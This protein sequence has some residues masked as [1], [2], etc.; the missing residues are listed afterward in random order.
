M[1]IQLYNT[2]DENVKLDKTLT[3]K[4]E[5]TGVLREPATIIN[6]VVNIQAA[7]LPTSNYAY[8]PDFG[9]YYFINNITALR[10]NLFQLDMSVD[11]LMSYKDKIKE[12]LVTVS[13]QENVYDD[14]LVDNMLP[15]ANYEQVETVILTTDNPFQNN[16]KYVLTIAGGK[17]GDTTPYL[18]KVSISRQFNKIA[19]TCF[20][21]FTN[22][23][24]INYQLKD[25]ANNT[26][27][28]NNSFTIKD[29]DTSSYISRVLFDIDISTLSGSY[30]LQLVANT[31]SGLGETTIAE[32]NIIYVTI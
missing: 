4:I 30:Q 20:G 16:Y 24:T 7:A 23:D 21:G 29:P 19:V 11:V 18:N 26:A 17:S 2:T 31:V 5:L 27:L 10:N 3:N 14:Y 28:V 6:P 1:I 13:R 8:I 9:R 25:V 12:L 32:S 22:G 15:L